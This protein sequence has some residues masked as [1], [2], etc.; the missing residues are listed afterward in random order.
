VDGGY[1]ASV[2]AMVRVWSPKLLGGFQAASQ[3]RA[4]EEADR[5]HD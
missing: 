1:A 4:E 3:P 5:L 2:V